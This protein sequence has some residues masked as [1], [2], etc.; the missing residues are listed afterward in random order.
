ME[1]Y[2]FLVWSFTDYNGKPFTLHKR[3]EKKKIPTDKEVDAH[4]WSLLILI[5][6]NLISSFYYLVFV[7]AFRFW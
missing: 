2:I 5:H 3:Q 4:N 6:F 1:Q 7:P